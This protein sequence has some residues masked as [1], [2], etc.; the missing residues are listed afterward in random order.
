MIVR[1][2]EYELDDARDR[3]DVERVYDW[4]A[5]TYW[6]LNLTPGV[7]RRAVN[8]SSLVVGAY[9]GREQVGCLRVVSDRA[10]FAWIAD[11]FVTEAHRGR[12]LARAMVRFAF[13]HP[14]HQGLRRWML[15]THDAHGVYRSLGFT[16]LP[17]PDQMMIYRPEIT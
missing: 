10:T 15:A 5:T 12:G 11:V 2:G 7:L 13:H 17:D 3:F 6:S 4:L 14:E 9:R 8:G 1:H 16:P